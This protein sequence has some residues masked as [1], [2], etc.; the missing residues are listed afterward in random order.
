MGMVGSMEN[1]SV[2]DGMGGVGWVWRYRTPEEFDDLWLGS[3]GEALTGVWFEGT[4]VVEGEERWVPVFG[5][6]CRWL[7]G[8]FAGRPPEW[9]PVMRLVGATGFRRE[10][11]EEMR[12]IPFGATATYGEI[13]AA[14]ARRR[15]V[16]RMSAQ[17]VGGAAG[18]NPICIVIPCHRVVGAGG[19]LT[20]YGG[21]LHNK[22]ALLEL[23]RRGDWVRWRSPSGRGGG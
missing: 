16:A 18:W 3:D 21:G 19:A 20:G 4:R 2:K 15:G 9:V 22:M 13:A 8:Y 5:D 11:S 1:G 7:D 6:A 23:E 10:V 14:I 12:R 17:A